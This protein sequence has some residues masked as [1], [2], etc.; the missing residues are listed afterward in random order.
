MLKQGLH[1]VRI[2]DVKHNLGR[3]PSSLRGS[4]CSVLPARSRSLQ[5]DTVPAAFNVFLEW[6]LNVWVAGNSETKLAFLVGSLFSSFAWNTAAEEIQ[7]AIFRLQP[8]PRE[9]VRKAPAY[10]ISAT[11][12]HWP[13]NTLPLC[14]NCSLRTCC[15]ACIKAAAIVS[16]GSVM[17]HDDLSRYRRLLV[18]CN[19]LC[20]WEQRGHL[21]QPVV[22]RY[23]ITLNEPVPRGSTLLSFLLIMASLCI[24]IYSVVLM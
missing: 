12:Q 2:A 11:K 15:L 14:C 23:Q 8:L 7:R 10:S 16:L 20:L 6:M 19:V 4:K 17:V 3:F 5:S 18:F 22:W 1:W 21:L 13:E 24:L 9:N